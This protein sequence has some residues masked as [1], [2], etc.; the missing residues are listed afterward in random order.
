[1][2]DQNSGWPTIESG[3]KYPCIVNKD[4]TRV[5]MKLANSNNAVSSSKVYVPLCFTMGI[6]KISEGN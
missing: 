1:M 4:G 3:T 2:V 6:I 5:P